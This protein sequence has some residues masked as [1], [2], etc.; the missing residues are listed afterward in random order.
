MRQTSMRCIGAFGQRAGAPA[1]G[2]EEG[3]LLRLASPAA[4]Q[5]GVEI[6]FEIVMRR[7]LVALAAFFVEAHPP[8]LALGE[9]ILDA[10][11]DGGADAGEAE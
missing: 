11:A 9:I 8:A 6:G 2:A 10:H 4:S 1:R 5:I 3:V 7:H